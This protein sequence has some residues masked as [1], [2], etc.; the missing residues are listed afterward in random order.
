MFGKLYHSQYLHERE[1][2]TVAEVE[3]IAAQQD[4]PTTTLSVAWILATPAVTSVALGAS[5]TGQV[6]ETLAPA[7]HEFDEA[8]KRRLRLADAGK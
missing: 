4:V 1:F 3:A 2:D 7:N 8:V 6:A 5:R